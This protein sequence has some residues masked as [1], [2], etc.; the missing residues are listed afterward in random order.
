MEK[1]CEAKA[2]LIPLRPTLQDTAR[3]PHKIGEYLA[4]GNPIITTNYG[5]VKHHFRQGETAFIAEEYKVA[6]YA[7][8]MQ[9]ILNQ[10]EMAK[11]VGKKGKEY[12]LAQFDCTVH[13]MRMLT[14]FQELSGEP[15]EHFDEDRNNPKEPELLAKSV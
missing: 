2:L 11:A 4:S 5:E 6:A 9:L 7:E 8:Q 1:Y 12:G 15:C 14:F 10:P 3:F 13:G